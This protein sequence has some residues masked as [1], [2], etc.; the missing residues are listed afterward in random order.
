VSMIAEDDGLSLDICQNHRFRVV[1]KRFGLRGLKKK[2]SHEPG[3]NR[4]YDKRHE[5]KKATGAAG[6]RHSSKRTADK[7][8]LNEGGEGVHRP[9][10][11]RRACESAAPSPCGRI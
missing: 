3:G 10:K 6:I 11:A 2:R 9:E 1:W 8:G 7:T 4:G 5:D